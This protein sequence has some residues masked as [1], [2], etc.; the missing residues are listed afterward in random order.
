MLHV[1]YIDLAPSPGGSIHSLHQLVSH[2]D[3]SE[4]QPSVALSV[5][6]DFDAF[7]RLGIPVRRVRTPWWEGPGAGPVD[8]LRR[9][10]VGERMRRPGIQGRLWHR[11]GDLRRLGRDLLPAART[12]AQVYRQA[13]PDL[14][15]LNDAIPLVRPALLASRWTGVPALVHARSF[16]LP[17][18]FDRRA[19]TPAIAGMIFIS[20]AVA[21]AQLAALPRRPASCVIPNALD[22]TQFDDA[23]DATPVRAELG[24]PP[25]VPLVGMVGRI[26]PWKGQLVFVEAM[27]RLHRRRPDLYG[28]IVGAAEGASGERYR[29]AVSDRIAALG[30]A[31]RLYLV[32]HRRDVPRL[33]A[34]VDAVAHCSV[35]P[36]PFG[37][38]IIE[39]MAAGRPVV[40][41]AAG[42]S[43]EIITDGVDGLL[44]PP[45][46]PD[47]LAAALERLLADRN[48]ARRLGQAARQTVAS[49]YRIDQ[50]AAA[51]QAFYDDL[52][53]QHR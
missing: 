5:L 52:L 29:Q 47:A 37:R 19:L 8:R 38:V 43:V 51:V 14:V 17:T 28:V 46:D 49:R 10:P 32:G 7:D 18:A 41:S 23:V 35:Q 34:A 33:M 9:G 21:E 15:H 25:G 42:G 1:L 40:A 13:R 24:I 3:R 30:L 4:V 50:H 11:L 31:E 22:L 27:A 26:A 2:L 44:T 53:S 48:L 39:G 6:L 16:L 36:E 12:L 45:N 20:R